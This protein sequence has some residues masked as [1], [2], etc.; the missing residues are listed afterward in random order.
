MLPGH[1]QPL[2]AHREPE[3]VARLSH[4]PSPREFFDFVQANKPVVIEGVL[5]A[6][7]L[8]SNWGMDE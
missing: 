5:N 4:V 3:L 7:N 6:T 8:L 2:G 1:L